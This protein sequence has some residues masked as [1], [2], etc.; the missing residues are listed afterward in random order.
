[1]S[2]KKVKTVPDFAEFSARHQ[3][4]ISIGKDHFRSWQYNVI[5][6][7]KSLSQEEIKKVL[8]DTSHPFAICMENWIGDFNIG[9]AIRNANGFN[10]KEI[11]Y[12]GNRKIDRRS[13]TG[14]HNYSDITFINTIYEL[15]KLKEKYVFIGIDNI[16]GAVSLTEYKW[17]PN[18]LMIFGSEG[19]G[20]TDTM[21]SFCKD[22]VSIPMM[23]SVRSFNASSASAIVMYDYITKYKKENQK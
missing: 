10:A 14:V 20:L 11:F 5:D 22:I 2:H 17:E 6:E 12:I 23:G 1:M 3:E 9:S 13:M 8:K 21:I 15:L 4:A 19:T 18:S 7:F 16:K